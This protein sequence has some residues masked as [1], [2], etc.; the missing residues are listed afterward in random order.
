MLIDISVPIDPVPASRP[1]VTGKGWSYYPKP[2]TRFKSE[3]R[4]TVERMMIRKMAGSLMVSLM[5]YVRKP[6]TTKLTAPK[7]DVDNYAKAVLDGLNG[8]AWCDDSQV[9]DLSVS[10]RWTDGEPRIDILVQ[11]ANIGGDR[12][13]SMP[14]V[15]VQGTGSK[16][17]Q[18]EGVR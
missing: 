10:K 3:F 18:P 2:Y 12:F 9:T 5:V 8:V 4:K 7:P 11:P 14:E 1:R 6:K 17:R 13:G 15:P 16:R